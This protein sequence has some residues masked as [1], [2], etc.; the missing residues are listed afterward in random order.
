MMNESKKKSRK[1]KNIPVKWKHNTKN[2]LVHI[3]NSPLNEYIA[4]GPYIKTAGRTQINGLMIQ[5]PKFE[6]HKQ[7]KYK[8]SP[9]ALKSTKLKQRKQYN[10]ST[11]IRVPFLEDKQ[12]WQTFFPI[13]KR[14]STH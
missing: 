11:N 4:L 1:N 5:L 8:T 10:K 13:T 2:P 14:E 12:N 9:L 6:S 7:P 3:E